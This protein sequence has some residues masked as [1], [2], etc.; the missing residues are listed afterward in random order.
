MPLAQCID[1]LSDLHKENDQDD[2]FFYIGG[3]EDQ[4]L[5]FEN[6]QTRNDQNFYLV[7]FIKEPQIQR[8]TDMIP[9][10]SL[11][12]KIYFTTVGH[13]KLNKQILPPSASVLAFQPEFLELGENIKWASLSVFRN[14]ADVTTVMLSPAEIQHVESVF[15]ILHAEYKAHTNFR[16][17]MIGT[18]ARVLIIILSR[19][20]ELQ[21]KN[22]E[23][24]K[25]YALYNRYIS[26]LEDNFKK[27]H[28]V[29]EYAAMMNMTESRLNELIKFQSGKTAKLHIHDRILLEAKRLLYHTEKSVKEIAYALGF[30]YDSYFSRFFKRMMKMSPSDYRLTAKTTT[31]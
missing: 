9:P 20:C 22:P 10:E 5:R 31:S 28:F 8:Q 4:P 25:D 7:I 3:I 17:E 11:A 18:Y 15:D 29:S 6:Y 13:Q 23:L 21:N 1:H 27:K 26:A 16:E 24:P 12:G 30:R 2:R 14:L 19:L